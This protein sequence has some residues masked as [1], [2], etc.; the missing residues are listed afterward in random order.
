M[1]LQGLT[2]KKRGLDPNNGQKPSFLNLEGSNYTVILF[3][4]VACHSLAKQMRPQGLACV[5]DYVE[6]FSVTQLIVWNHEIVPEYALAR[7]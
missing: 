1:L 2:L 3:D 7:R 4:D 5:S 6:Y